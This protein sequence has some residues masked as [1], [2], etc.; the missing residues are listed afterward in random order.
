MG[1]RHRQ[2][3]SV[4]PPVY[5]GGSSA[6]VIRKITRQNALDPRLEPTDR[7]MQ[8]WAESQGSD[9]PNESDLPPKVRLPPLPEP[10]AVVTDQIVLHSPDYWRDFI[11]SWYRSSKPIEI[12]A[13]DLGCEKR[14]VYFE[15]KIVLAYLLGRLTQA[16]V[17]IASYRFR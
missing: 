12:I 10:V 8:R 13:K 15:R 16:G 14:S 9:L 4:I 1:H 6:I 3:K 7:H 5:V 2:L 11:F 17:R